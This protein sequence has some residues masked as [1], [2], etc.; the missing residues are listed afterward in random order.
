[1]LDQRANNRVLSPQAEEA[2]AGPRAEPERPVQRAPRTLRLRLRVHQLIERYGVDT[3]RKG[4]WRSTHH[5]PRLQEVKERRSSRTPAGPPAPSSRST[6]RLADIKA[7]ASSGEYED[8]NFSS[9][10]RPPLARVRCSRRLR[11]DGRRP[12]GDRSGCD[13]RAE[14]AEPR[15][16][17]GAGGRHLRRELQRLDDR[18]AGYAQAG[19]HRLRAAHPRRQPRGLAETAKL[20]GIETKPDGLPA[21]GLGGLTIGVSP[22]EMANA[23][24]TLA[25]GGIRHE[26]PGI[27]EVKFPNG[28]WR[29]SAT[30]TG[31]AS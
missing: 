29:S 26:S 13:I 24:A 5:R 22:L 25:S 3:L 4:D 6:P 16:G 19:Q 15:H 8:R 14:A 23:Y 28:D 17:V 30:R 20:K 21:E 10:P 7:M 1:M 9:R 18:H 27:E 31:S 2:K 11:A 12:R